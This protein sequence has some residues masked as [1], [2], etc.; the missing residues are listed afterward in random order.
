MKDLVSTI[1]IR[2]HR[3]TRSKAVDIL[4]RTLNEKPTIQ[5]L[6]NEKRLHSVATM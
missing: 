5:K 4:D 1:D 6:Y 3:A 2:P